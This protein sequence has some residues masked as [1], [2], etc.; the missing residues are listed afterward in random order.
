MANPYTAYLESKLMAS[1]PLQLVHLAY[2]GAIEAILEARGHLAENRIV[3]RIQSITRAQQIIIQLQASLDYQQGAELSTRLSSLYDYMLRRLNE[4]N[5]LSTDEPFA[6]VQNLLSTVGD[7]WREISTDAP[8]SAAASVGNSSPSP[9]AAEAT[10]SWVTESAVASPWAS[11]VNTSSPWAVEGTASAWSSNET[12]ASPWAT[13]TTPSAWATEA[14]PSP[15]AVDNTPSPWVSET[16]YTPS[17][18]APSAWATEEP[19]S[20]WMTSEPAVYTPRGYSL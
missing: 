11:E 8:L 1:S 10:S 17:E 9:W 20:P 12:T 5:R 19:T 2:Q 7:A 14:T 16:T 6:E 13:E 3:Q 4:G 15:W 18:P